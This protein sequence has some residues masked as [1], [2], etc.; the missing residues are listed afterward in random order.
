MNYIDIIAIV[1]V[2]LGLV[3]GV[4]I[5]FRKKAF[6]KVLVLLS[7]AIALWVSFAFLDLVISTD[8]YQ[9]F[10]LETLRNEVFG[11]WIAFLALYIVSSLLL[12]FLLWLITLPLSHL[13]T[14]SNGVLCRVLGGLNGL[15]FSFSLVVVALVIIASIPSLKDSIDGL[16]ESGSFSLSLSIYDYLSSLFGASAA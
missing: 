9:R 11:K 4:L 12:S 7:M 1:V 10:M 8:W 16:S 5:G 14:D 15:I 13:L 2:A 3:L 6:N